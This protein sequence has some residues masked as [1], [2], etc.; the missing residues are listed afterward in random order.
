MP[1]KYLE[2]KLYRQIPG[3]D[4]TER[5]LFNHVATQ[6]FSDDFGKLTQWGKKLLHSSKHIDIS[7]ASS[8]WPHT[9]S[10]LSAG[11]AGLP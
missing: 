5:C 4:G 6:R 2:K 7:L 8:V 10:A 9:V 1:C 3:A 11:P